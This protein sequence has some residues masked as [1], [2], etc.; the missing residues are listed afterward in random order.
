MFLG[1]HSF[2]PGLLGN[3]ILKFLPNMFCKSILHVENA[4]SCFSCFA[5]VM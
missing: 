5:K 1:D 2:D 4:S 3:I